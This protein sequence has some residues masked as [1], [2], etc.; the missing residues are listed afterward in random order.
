MSILR[1]HLPVA[2]LTLALLSPVMI[3]GCA[4]RASYTVYDPYYRDNHVWDNNEVVY[5][6]RWETET[7]REHRDFKKRKADEQKEYWD[8]RHKH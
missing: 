6:Q 1:K 4:A 2:L 3:S 5:Y 8:W 7:H